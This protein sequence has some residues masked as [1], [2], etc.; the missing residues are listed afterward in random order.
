[1]GVFTIEDDR[2]WEVFPPKRSFP[3]QMLAVF[4]YVYTVAIGVALIVASDELCGSVIV[5]TT[6]LVIWAVL[7]TILILGQAREGKRFSGR[8]GNSGW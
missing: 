8:G 7:L 2:E 1:M 5:A 6:V 3:L 4:L